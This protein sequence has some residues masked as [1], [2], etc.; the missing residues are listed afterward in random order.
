MQRQGRIFLKKIKSI[1]GTYSGFVQLR[2]PYLSD[3]LGQMHYTNGDVY[4]GDWKSGKRHGNG[5][6]VDPEG[7]VYTGQ[8]SNDIQTGYGVYENPTK[9]YK[10]EGN[11]MNKIY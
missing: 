5:R 2:E 11:W 1:I 6:L 3:G 9:L 4:E 10:Y 7:S 8:W